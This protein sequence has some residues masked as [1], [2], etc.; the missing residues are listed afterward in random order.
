[1][2]S[3]QGPLPRLFLASNED[4]IGMPTAAAAPPQLSLT[5][6]IS[7]SGASNE[8]GVSFVQ[9]VQRIA[10]M[11]NRTED[12]KWIAQYASTCFADSA[13]EWYLTL[14]D[15]TQTSWKKLRLALV[16]RYPAQ[17][18]KRTHDALG[19]I[20]DV[21]EAQLKAKAEISA[22]AKEKAKEA[23]KYNQMEVDSMDEQD[24][25]PVALGDEDD[26]FEEEEEPAP[27]RKTTAARAKTTK[28]STSKAA[29]KKAP[30]KKGKALFI[31]SDEDDIED[32]D[33]DIPPPPKKKAAGGRAAVFNAIS[34]AP[35][36]KKTATVTK[37]PTK[38][39]TAGRS[40][41]KAASAKM[42]ELAVTSNVPAH[43]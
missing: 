20:E 9:S 32:D 10:F 3:Q 12:D 22:K 39:A 35:P 19:A 41:A 7:F 34:K 38:R 8:S 24:D 29:R 36:K 2:S 33:D 4:S 40:A 42:Q 43:L 28:A 27:K 13:L 16:Q 5:Q 31:W 25:W 26:G 30:A 18:S 6:W 14:E 15:K 17:P 1:M 21:A 11:Q 23:G 37:A